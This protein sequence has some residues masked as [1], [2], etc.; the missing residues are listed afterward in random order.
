[1]TYKHSA[2]SGEW[3]RMVSQQKFNMDHL[4]LNSRPTKGAIA[5]LYTATMM[6]K[7]QSVTLE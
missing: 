6:D 4:R 2:T 5:H 1:M 7:T 3:L